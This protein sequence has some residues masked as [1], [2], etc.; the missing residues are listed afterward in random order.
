MGDV[1][2]LGTGK[3][4]QSDHPPL[5]LILNIEQVTAF[6]ALVN[7]LNFAYDRATQGYVLAAIKRA[8]AVWPDG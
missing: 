1:I 8:V 6:T 7:E 5:D 4:V 2:S 3:V